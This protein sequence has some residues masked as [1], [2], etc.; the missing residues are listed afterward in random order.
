MSDLCCDAY[1]QTYLGS[2]NVGLG[3]HG[4]RWDTG[5]AAP[6]ATITTYLDTRG[7]RRFAGNYQSTSSGIVLGGV[8]VE[9]QAAMRTGLL[10]REVD[11]YS[12]AGVVYGATL[13]NADYGGAAGYVVGLGAVVNDAIATLTT[14]A[15]LLE[16]AL[17]MRSY[18]IPGLGSGQVFV[19]GTA[20]PPIADG[21]YGL[22]RLNLWTLN[23]T[24]GP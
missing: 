13:L 23:Q 4:W 2:H 12:S 11:A 6:G 3:Q 15:Y 5:V 10:I 14:D 7:H 17:T 18:E 8:V 1:I 9:A 21:Y 19:T 22:G 16:I 24:V 20:E